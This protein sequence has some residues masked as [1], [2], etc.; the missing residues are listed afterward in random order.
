M[1]LNPVF[2]IL[3]ILVPLYKAGKNLIPFFM[4]YSKRSKISSPDSVL[5][6]LEGNIEIQHYKKGWSYPEFLFNG[7]SPV[8]GS[9]FIYMFNR[10]IK[11]FDL[12]HSPTLLAFSILPFVAYWLM[13][14]GNGQLLSIKK[15]A[16]LESSLV[17]GIIL[18]FA[19]GLHFCS[20]MGLAG[21]CFLPV[22]GFALIA[23]F[24]A[25]VYLMR[26]L[27][28]IK[29]TIRTKT[30]NALA[31][32]SILKPG[33]RISDRVKGYLFFAAIIFV[34]KVTLIAIGGQEWD[35]LIQAFTGGRD[36]LFSK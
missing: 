29:S 2:Y 36:F 34:L 24:P 7:V 15:L 12:N 5:D 8:L 19:Y 13:R 4:G 3:L 33:F 32:P 9:I 23:P 16:I 10:E 26:E 27:I 21:V 1:V 30:D 31:T 14:I 25:M 17:F 6:C 22:F 28:V 35:S 20:E 18:Y 11:P